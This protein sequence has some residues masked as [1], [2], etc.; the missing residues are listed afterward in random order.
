MVR[1]AY[2]RTK[3]RATKKKRA[4]AKKSPAEKKPR[5][6][7]AEKA[8]TRKRA[9]KRRSTRTTERKSGAKRP[10]AR[11]KA[12]KRR[13]S[14]AVPKAPKKA[15][16]APKKAVKKTSRKAPGKAKKASASPKRRAAGPRREKPLRRLRKLL[17]P[18][19][20]AARTK[21]RRKAEREALAKQLAKL[22]K[23]RAKLRNKGTKAKRTLRQKLNARLK[24]IA[25]RRTDRTLVIEK[26][27]RETPRA[28]KKSREELFEHFRAR[29]H[30][31][32]EIA[33]KKRQLPEVDYRERHIDSEKNTGEIR[34]IRIEQ[35]VNEGSI[36]SIMYKVRKAASRMSDF[37]PIWMGVLVFTGMGERLIGY[38]NRVLDA[39]DPDAA[40]FQTQGIEST[41]VRP[42]VDGMLISIEDL[43][44]EYADEEYTVV[45]CEHIKVMNY[46][47][48]HSR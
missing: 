44:T 8:L 15:R 36:E 18:G 48:M 3:A 10:A 47:R 26:L 33:R 25:K 13:V 27:P 34:I 37:Y 45:F 28:K 6:K 29:F 22:N 7:P 17:T 43:L 1:S 35:E 40:Q 31:L 11:K 32:H 23:D 2:G 14:S 42:T 38:G 24:A 46:A 20:K 16:K 5:K 19:Q 12:A 41:G 39:Q 9:T 4:R 30:E 21:A